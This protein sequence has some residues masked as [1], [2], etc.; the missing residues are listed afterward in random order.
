[1]SGSPREKKEIIKG[2]KNMLVFKSHVS[3]FSQRGSSGN[4]A[5]RYNNN[6]C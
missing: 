3:H 6:G 5:V 4:N 1:M 2:E